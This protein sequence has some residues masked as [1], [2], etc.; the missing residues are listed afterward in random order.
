MN[1]LAYAKRPAA[2]VG[3]FHS[4]LQPSAP[5]RPLCLVKE[6]FILCVRSIYVILFRLIRVRILNSPLRKKMLMSAVW[7]RKMALSEAPQ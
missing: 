2:R 3:T 5:S 7:N 6:E 1:N 4:L